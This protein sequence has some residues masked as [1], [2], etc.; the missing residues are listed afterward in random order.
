M[1]E[2]YLAFLAGLLGAGH[3]LGMCGG[4]VGAAFLAGHADWRGHAAYHGG[5]ILAYVGLATLAASL[6]GALV[7]TGLVGRAQGLLYIAAGL[8]LVWVGVRTVLVRPV[9]MG[10]CAGCV[11]APR[12]GYLAA[13]FANGV[14]PCALYF[15]IALKAAGTG[16]PM[17]GAGL[18]LA[19]GLGTVPAM[20]AAG[21]M[22]RWLGG[23]AWPRR[24]AGLGIA[25]LGLDA[26]W[27]GVKFFRVMLHL[28]LG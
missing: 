4:I 8:V 10:R 16:Q 21:V 12:A 22:A 1:A 20:L 19:F 27:N 18:G 11:A 2:P 17:A 26:V 15:S 14:M 28:P 23:S 9:L 24:L 6:G 5:R 13:G 3:C 7:L 25:L